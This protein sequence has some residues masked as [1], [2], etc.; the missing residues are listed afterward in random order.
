MFFCINSPEVL[1]EKQHDE[2]PNS[3]QNMTKQSKQVSQVNFMF[4]Q[5]HVATH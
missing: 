3:F 4:P 2:L 1:N 5:C